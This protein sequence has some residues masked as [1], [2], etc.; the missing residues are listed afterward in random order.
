MRI[1]VRFFGPAAEKAGTQNLTVE[2]IGTV[3]S[4]VD[5]TLQ[6]IP[7]LRDLSGNMKYARN[8]EYT[9]LNDPLREGDVV[10]FL[11]PVGGG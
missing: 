10:S 7:A 6:Q 4:V 9:S 11:P 5:A 3:Q 8:T 2:A 1:Q